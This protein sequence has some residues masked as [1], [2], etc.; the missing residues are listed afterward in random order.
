MSKKAL[1]DAIKTKVNGISGFHFT[2]LW[3]DQ[4]SREAVEDPIRYPAIFVEFTSIEW[5]TSIGS[6]IGVQRGSLEVVFRI[7]FKTLDKE[8]DFVFE[9]VD[10]FYKEMQ[11]FG[12]ECF[13]SFNRSSEE[14]D[15][16]YDNVIVW[17]Q[18]YETNLTDLSAANLGARLEVIEDVD[19]RIDSGLVI[20]PDD[21]DKK[22]IRTSSKEYF[23]EQTS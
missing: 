11:G 1:Y 15:T 12:G 13:S 2:D 7:V 9:K 17:L 8:N 19:A 18:S 4:V 21:N 6:N 22:I 5:E 16:D 14:Q 3:N 20:E 10:E 23:D